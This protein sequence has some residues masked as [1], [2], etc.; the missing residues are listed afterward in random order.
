MGV[1]LRCGNIRMA[2]QLLN[3]AQICAMRNQVAGEGV[4]QHMWRKF[5]RIDA[6][7]DGEVLEQL[8]DSPAC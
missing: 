7:L 2:Q 8:R 4:A 5:L 3:A 6:G 1:D